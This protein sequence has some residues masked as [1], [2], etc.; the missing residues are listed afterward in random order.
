MPNLPPVL[1]V[2]GRAFDLGRAVLADTIHPSLEFVRDSRIT[3]R[4]GADNIYVLT[5]VAGSYEMATDSVEG[6]VGSGQVTLFDIARPVSRRAFPGR[7]LCLSVGRELVDE[8]MPGKD[9]H[10]LRVTTG[11]SLMAEHLR[12]LRAHLPSMPM[13]AAT[14][15]VRSALHTL[16]ACVLP[17]PD[18]LEQAR[19]ALTEALLSRAKRYIHAHCE[20]PSLSPD[21]IAVA[22]GS[23]RSGLYRAFEPEGGVAAYIR[24]AR[25]QAARA[26]LQ[27]RD[28]HRR[29]G[30]IGYAYGFLSESQFSRAIRSAFGASPSELRRQDRFG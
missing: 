8:V 22:V 18:R 10:A 2:S 9:V 25:L 3:R 6:R 30:E 1:E 17:T 26:A 13:A 29:I 24:G 11:G 12:G 15:L 21:H 19:P 5:Q 23:S 27:N 4:D 28:D 14:H 7:T 20:E 16:A